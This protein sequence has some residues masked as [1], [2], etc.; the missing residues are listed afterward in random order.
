MLHM[1]GT[2]VPGESEANHTGGTGSI[3]LKGERANN[4]FNYWVDSK[5]KNPGMSPMPLFFKRSSGT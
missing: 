4:S 2:E 3:G 1:K 5:R